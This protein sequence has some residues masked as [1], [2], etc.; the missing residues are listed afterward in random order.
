[1]HMRIPILVLA[2]AA[3]ACAPK[4]IH[5]EPILD[6]NARVPEV[7]TTAADD[8][9]YWQRTQQLARDSIAAE[10]MAGCEG[11]V[12]DALTRG[13]VVL[14]MNETQL[15]AATRTTP[16]A[17]TVRRSGDASVFVPRSLQYTPADAV[18]EVVMVRLA[19]GRVQSYSYREP[20]GIRLIN[21]PEDATVQGRAAAMADAL[22]REGD[23]YAARG[24]FDLAL[25]R[26]DRSQI[27]KP[28]DALV[29]YRIAT[30]L[31]KMLRPIE[32]QIQYRLFLHQLE[33][34]RI[35]AQGDAY[36]KMAEAIA[37]A[38]QRITVLERR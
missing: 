37:H 27:L 16:G 19:D 26:Y 24:E 25:N 28:N 29:T 3:A 23:D 18:G 22:I 31:D 33:L 11:E 34:E 14:G 32:A 38:R 8:A 12:C 21:D 9:S 30:T 13:E 20:Q 5:Q 36:A 35:D 4:R 17:W 7:R 1:M 10:A 6:N 2:V 15:L